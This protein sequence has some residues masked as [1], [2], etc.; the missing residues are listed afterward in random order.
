MKK[1]ALSRLKQWLFVEPTLALLLS[2]VLAVSG[3]FAYEKMIKESLPDLQIPMA[4]ILTKW[5]GTSQTV[6]EKE[7]TNEL[8]EELRDIDGVKKFSSGSQFANSVIMVEFEA[9][10][11]N[12]ASLS[13]VRE[14]VARAEKNIPKRV[15]KPVVTAESIRN[16]PIATFMFYGDVPKDVLSTRVEE[17]RKK[18]LQLPGISKVRAFGA[19]KKYVRV[20]L[21]PAQLRLN[22]VSPLAV[23]KKIRAHADDLPLG[24][25][26]GREQPLSLKSRI[27]VHNIDQLRELPL[28]REPTGRIIRLQDVARVD[29]TEYRA[30]SATSFSENG[31][32][33][34]SGIA[35][36]LV[37]SAGRDTI[38]LVEAAKRVVEREMARGNWPAGLNFSVPFND[39]EVIEEELDK[40]L[41]SGLQSVLVVFLVLFFLL[42]WREATIAALCIPLT[43][44]GSV[45]GLWL[46]GYTFNV[47][48]VIGMVLALGL[49]VD[50]FILM[51]EGM[52][53][54]IYVKRESF[55][56]AAVNTISQYAVPSLAGTITTLL[57]FVPLANIGGLDGQFIR[58][59]P[60]TAAIC[61]TVSYL[62]SIVMAVPLSRFLLKRKTDEEH[63][64]IDRLTLSL[65]DKLTDW[66]SAYVTT[67][68]KSA[69]R[70]LRR[71]FYVLLIGASFVF[72]LP[73]VLYPLAD[74]RNMGITVELPIDYK[75]EESREI[76][77]ELA[78]VLREKPYFSSIL[79][80]AGERDFV[81]EGSAEDRLS[82]S[83]GGN[84][85][86]FTLL[87][88]PL[89][90]REQHAYQYVPAI[91][92]ELNKVLQDIPA[93]RL[94]ITSETGASTNES[95]IQ[96]NISGPDLDKLQDISRDVQR[97]LRQ[98][99][100]LNNVRDNL[101][102]TRTEATVVAKRELL[103]KYGITEEDFSAQLSFYLGDMK[104]SKLRS[105]QGEDLDIRVEA[106]WDSK[107][108]KLGGPETWAEWQ[109]I[110]VVTPTGVWLPASM[111]ADLHLSQVPL[112][113]SHK[114]GQRSVTIMADTFTYPFKEVQA[115]L[116]P[117]LEALQ[118]DWPQA[119]SYRWAGEVE[120]AE[121]TY[122]GAGIAFVIA[123]LGV[124]SILV[125]Q[126]RSFAQPALI[127]C[128]VAFGLAGVFVGFTIMA[129]P[130]S[131]PAVIGMIALAGICVN[132][133]IVL[134]DTMNRHLEN[135][136]PVQK[137]A[138]RGAADRFRPIVSTTLTT[139]LGL[140]PLA[141]A[142]AAWRPL[143]AAIIFG[144]L[145]A[146]VAAMLV[147]PAM[148]VYL[149]RPGRSDNATA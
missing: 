31:S 39:A 47:M 97:A 55:G 123:L 107:K 115:L 85:I 113:I 129:Y 69:L 104:L 71:S 135:G 13:S 75:L 138:A 24:V 131:F 124:F 59:I 65:E 67:N 137:A 101:G 3:F 147:V 119:Y 91:R 141:I 118:A 125:L 21:L 34:S 50:D 81:Y 46:L 144:E 99:E 116:N 11:D 14:A 41:I 38:Q 66:L 4:S 9:G 8:E 5:H 139:L 111:L 61:L 108:G 60:V 140:M 12:K 128:T 79:Q 94:L 77:N 18:L 106:Y 68:A 146:T 126:F 100:G 80:V 10:S 62:V 51:M 109:S 136:E 89:K 114:G 148:F 19:Q 30:Y 142:D 143:C 58:A 25:Y 110:N 92:A 53:E 29:T 82:V 36:S 112:T 44:L 145:A 56:E 95:P 120:L 57:I 43:F 33:F 22:Q 102:Q 133:G 86:G 16:M 42:T 26:E 105:E 93:Y 149:Q 7:V 134:V 130:L 70:V 52:H 83:S 54:G 49:L 90:E 1:S 84:I 15:D 88:K 73:V 37:K 96:L 6:M 28:R 63:A 32:E 87:F 127:L 64:L 78:A 72:F 48:V 76:A 74:G 117:V 35:L 17:L 40:T 23:V 45:I 122:G 103:A 132:D 2:L 98:V 121:E 20:Q 27:A